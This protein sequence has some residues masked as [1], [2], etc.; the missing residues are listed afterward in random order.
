MGVDG[1]DCIS[2]KIAADGCMTFC[3]ADRGRELPDCTGLVVTV[4]GLTGGATGLICEVA[5][6][7]LSAVRPPESGCITFMPPA[8]AVVGAGVILSWPLKDKSVSCGGRLIT[9]PTVVRAG[10][11]V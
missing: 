3:P 4:G 9:D 6:L 1:R 2:C 7:S 5:V 8:E 11:I 10:K